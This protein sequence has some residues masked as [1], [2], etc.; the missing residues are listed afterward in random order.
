MNFSD[1]VINEIKTPA[2]DPLFFTNAIQK[3][4][5]LETSLRPAWSI[6]KKAIEIEEEFRGRSWGKIKD[7]WNIIPLKKVEFVKKDFIDQAYSKEIQDLL[8]Y[9][10]M[11]GVDFHAIDR[12]IRHIL[13]YKGTDERWKSRYLEEFRAVMGQQYK[14]EKGTYID[15]LID[16]IRQA[17]DD[18]ENYDFSYS[19]A[20]EVMKKTKQ[21][22]GQISKYI[23]LVEKV[24]DQLKAKL[25]LRKRQAEKYYSGKGGP[26]DIHPTTKP[27]EVLY[28]ATPFLKEIQA[29][30]LKVGEKK[31]LGG[32]TSGGISFTASFGV[33]KE[34]ARNFREV[35]AISKNQVTPDQV[36]LMAKAQG[37]DLSKTSPYIEWM[38]RKELDSLNLPRKKEYYTQD[39]Y[40]AFELFRHFVAF[41]PHR[42]DPLFFGVRAD[43]FENYDPKNVGIIAAKCDMS[44][45]IEYL[46]SMEEYRMPPEAVLSYKI[47]PV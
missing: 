28:H 6:V 7:L 8:D 39:R 33:A 38:R 36:I 1:W 20:M 5:E 34:I 32:D 47:I 31:A 21:I 40:Y 4:R 23:S 44:K 30:G 3:L 15:N 11:K 14:T 10:S 29:S 26:G 35:I 27:V 18:F 42:Y 19:Y 46:S 41:A 22:F 12:Q 25:D 24:E 13:E 9:S 45:V 16:E 43:D 2:T 37:V 17:K